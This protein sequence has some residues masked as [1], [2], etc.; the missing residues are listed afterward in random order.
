MP[1]LFG[2]DIA[3]IVGA[4]MGPGF[5]KAT[6]TRVSPTDRSY[7]YLSDGTNPESVSYDCRAIIEPQA[8]VSAGTFGE[9]S[10]GDLLAEERTTVLVLAATLP[11]G[12]VPVGGDRITAEGKVYSVVSVDR[13]PAAAT[14]S[15]TCRGV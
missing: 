2:V 3:G 9:F 15:L 4:S 12:V 13:D 1:K 10:A 11:A 14:Y 8:K 7:T 5:P 6:L